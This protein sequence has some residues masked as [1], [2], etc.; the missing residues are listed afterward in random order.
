MIRKF[1][2]IVAIGAGLVLFSGCA[3][4]F[5]AT[6][7]AD[8][9]K[10]LTESA[11]P[12]YAALVADGDV[13][14]DDYQ[15]GFELFSDCMN[16]QG[17]TVSEPHLSPVDGMALVWEATPGAGRAA[18]EYS[19]DLA[20]CYDPYGTLEAIYNETGPGQMDEPLRAATQE[21]LA[22]EG[23]QVPDTALNTTDM[24]AY[25]DGDPVEQLTVLTDC[26]VPAATKLYPDIPAF[27]IH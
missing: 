14:A 26:I 17:Q 8:A 22:A 7:V 9:V 25:V 24:R 2:T 6:P 1:A 4:A 15:A 20:D 16:A 12:E 5:V 10:Q 13:S 21:C 27:P 11:P 18:T 23:Y 3:S 19:A